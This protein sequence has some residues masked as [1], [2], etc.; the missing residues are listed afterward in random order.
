AAAAEAAT[1]FGLRGALF[2]FRLLTVIRGGEVTSPAIIEHLPPTLATLSPV[3]AFGLV[4][5][6]ALASASMIVSWRRWRLDHLA[7]AIVFTVLALLARRNVALLGFGVLPLV[8]AGLGPWAWM[9]DRWLRRRRALAAVAEV[10]LAGLLIV[11][12]VRLVTDDWY[13]G[14]AHLTRTFGLGRSNLLF[15]PGASDWLAQHAPAARVFNDDGLGGWL[16]W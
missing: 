8:A 16:L 10:G 1:P 7:L 13:R 4:A 6:L 2:P 12:T 15:S 3:A 11:P 14:T 9:L 5:L